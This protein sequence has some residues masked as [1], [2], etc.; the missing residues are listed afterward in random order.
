ME[1]DSELSRLQDVI[2]VLQL[3]LID[4]NNDKNKY[5]KEIEILKSMNNNLKDV[6]IYIE[7]FYLLYCRKIHY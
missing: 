3:N 5:L 2:N 1:S 6:Y 7:L 4:S